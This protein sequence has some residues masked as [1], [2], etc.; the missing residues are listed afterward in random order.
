MAI[1]EHIRNSTPHRLY[2]NGSPESVLSNRGNGIVVLILKVKIFNFEKIDFWPKI[3]E[4]TLEDQWSFGKLCTVT[5][6][7]GATKMDCVL[8]YQIQ[9]YLY[10]R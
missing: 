8:D 7:C 4:Y 1:W 2:E 10:T 3:Y 9:I 5:A 6:K